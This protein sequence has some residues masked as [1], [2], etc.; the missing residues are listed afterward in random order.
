MDKVAFHPELAEGT[1]QTFTVKQFNQLKDFIENRIGIKIP[2][3]KKIMLESRLQKRL[4][5]LKMKSF[6]EYF[7]YV[8]STAEGQKEEIQNLVHSVTTH[9]TDFFRERDHFDQLSSIILPQYTK[10]G[11]GIRRPLRIWSAGCSSGQEVYT[12]AIVMHEYKINHAPRLSFSILGS[13]ISRNVLETAKTGIYQSNEIELLSL[14]LKRRYFLK[15]RDP[16]SSAVRIKSGVRRCTQFVQLNLLHDN[17]I[18]SDKIDFIFCRNVLIYF[19]REDQIR[20][21]K[22]IIKCLAPGGFLFV[23][24]S[25]AIN[26]FHLPL[27]AWKPTIYQVVSDDSGSNS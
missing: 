2:D 3:A 18:L 6:D 16:G 26:S 23:G 12:L 11:I 27:K 10:D 4:R 9:K 19:N 13:D 22:K 14:E 8:F 20:I 7:E 17:Y 15:H 5:L 24:H 25:E 21:L 1:I